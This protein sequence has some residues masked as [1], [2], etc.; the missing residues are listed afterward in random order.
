MFGSFFPF[1]VTERTAQHCARNN[2]TAYPGYEKEQASTMNSGLATELTAPPGAARPASPPTREPTDATA[3]FQLISLYRLRPGSFL[4]P[5][6]YLLVA[7]LIYAGW[8]QRLNWPLSAESGLGYTLGIVGGTLMLLLLL[9]PLRKHSRLMRRLGP[10]KYWFRAHMLFGVL[11][12]L[13]ILFHS[14]FQLG[15]LNSNTA[16]FCMLVVASSG[17]VG[18]YFYSRIHHGLYG[19]KATLQELQQHSTLLKASL[20]EQ[21]EQA[22]RLLTRLGAFES[23]VSRHQRNLLSSL[24]TLVS[25]GIRT[26]ALYL[27]ITLSPIS[28]HAPHNRHLVRHISAHLSS[29]R[30]VAEFHFY[31]RLF[32]LWHVLHFPLFLMLVLSGVVHV[33][34]VH[35]Y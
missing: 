3:V 16:L 35:M 19:S 5:L 12:P 30:K 34:A 22:P 9:Y 13:C 31:E 25:L 17:L 11:G 21:L 1:L 2:N 28:R 20:S 10:V 7:F 18:R 23:T 32:A 33:I 24:F 6:A 4:V 15:S 26:W 8:Q 27:R 14:G 29:I